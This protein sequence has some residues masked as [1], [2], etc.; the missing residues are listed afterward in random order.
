MITNYLSEQTMQHAERVSDWQEAIKLASKPLLDKAV[1]E[2]RYVQSMIQSVEDNGPYIVLKDYFA[3]PHAK[4]GEGV[5][6][7]G[8]ALLTLDEAVDLKGNPVKVFLVL[9]AVDSTAH[10]EALS[11]L[12]ELLMDDDIYDVFLSGDNEAIY[13]ELNKGGKDNV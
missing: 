6:E 1:I 13:N 4:A 5:N 2:P 11:E 9:A 7:V 12:S 8:M 10:L 3:L